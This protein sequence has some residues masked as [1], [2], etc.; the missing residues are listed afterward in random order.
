MAQ[1]GV[2]CLEFRLDEFVAIEID[3]P[4]MAMRE[5]IP[6]TR[7]MQEQLR[8]AMMPGPSATVTEAAPKRRNVSAAAP[9]N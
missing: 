5:M 9:I 3:E 8:V 6:K 1:A 2:V 4:D 7:L